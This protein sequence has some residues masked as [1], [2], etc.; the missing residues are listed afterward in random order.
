MFDFLKCTEDESAL[1]DLVE[2]DEYYKSMKEF[3]NNKQN[4]IITCVTV[5]L[6]MIGICIGV[7]LNI[8]ANTS[9]T[10]DISTEETEVT[11]DT[12]ITLLC[13]GIDKQVAMDE[14]H[15]ETNSIGQADGIFV[16]SID[17]E[18]KEVDIVA[19][20]RDTIVN[21]EKYNH[22][23]QYM[24]R[25]DAQICLQYAYADGME[26]SCELTVDRVE[27]LF[28]ETTID[29]YISINIEAIMEINDAVGGIEVTVDDEYTAL[30][31]GIPVGT[32]LNLTGEN[33]MLYLRLRDKGV[34]GSAYSR[35]DRIKEYI[36]KVIPKGLEAIKENPG[37]IADMYKT[38]DKHMVTDI[39]VTDLV[40]IVFSVKDT[41]AE[42]IHFHTIQG[43]IILGDD[44]YEEFYPEESQMEE[45][46]KKLAD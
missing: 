41:S 23:L 6:L 34:A 46:R 35:M 37:L 28:P 26:Y 44:G 21:I 18:T 10:E 38:L 4:V 19:I 20:P 5:L 33:T 3:F 36:T 43:E 25:E 17:K 15:P 13:L 45:L 2:K 29:G 14:R 9:D 27:E 7:C 8:G 24:G 40:N 30:H 11:E 1:L 31:M 22:K 16:I 32:T 12:K 42:N 39:G